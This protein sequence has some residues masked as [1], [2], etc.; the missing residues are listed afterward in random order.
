[1]PA[2]DR[3]AALA[4]LAQILEAQADRLTLVVIRNGEEF[5]RFA[6]APA[7]PPGTGD[8]CKD[9]ILAVLR[10]A[11]HRLTTDGILE[12]LARDGQSWGESTVKIKLAE[13]VEDDVLDN[14]ARAKPRGYGV[15]PRN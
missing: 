3:K 9:A 7:A 15:V 4:A 10:E 2:S 11:G 12:R 5:A 13:M 14:D 8:A 6:L 1:M